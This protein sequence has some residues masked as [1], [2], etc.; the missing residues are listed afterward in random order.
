MIGDAWAAAD[1]TVC[2][3]C[4]RD[5]CDDPAHLPPDSQPAA[6]VAP[7]VRPRLAVRA[8]ALLDTRAPLEIVEGIAWADSLTV[9]VGESSAGKTFVLL[10][11]EAAISDGVR[12]H[13]RDVLGGSVVHVSFEGDALGLRLRALQAVAG[14][15]LRH[16][17]VIRASDPLSPRLTRDGEEPSRGERAIA[18]ELTALADDIA[19]ANEPPIVLL[20]VDTVRA[21]MTGSEDSSEHTAAYLRAVRRLMAVVP[22][23]ACILAHHAGWQDGED[24]KRRE[25]GSSAWRG[26]SDGTLYLEAGAYDREHGTCPLVLRTLKVRDGEK[27]PPL[28]LVRRRVDLLELDR[29]GQPVTSCVV[30]RDH[31]SSD[32]RQAEQQA[33]AAAEHRDLDLSV[34][35]AVQARPEVATSQD[36]IRQAAGVARPVIHASLARLI[37]SGWLT[38]PERQRHP[39]T[40]TAAGRAALQEQPCRPQ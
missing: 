39:Y 29:R 38:P 14:H 1:P 28:H 30:E 21:S 32:D 11:L 10:G 35:R 24:R 3:V 25:R 22:G 9:M 13:G 20:V 34:L 17:Y 40:L 23:A 8:A 33:A 18:D 27:P 31:R 15:R 7:R 12:W 19:N 26:N 36:A 37:Q 5:A 16:L 4:E 2:A 6:A